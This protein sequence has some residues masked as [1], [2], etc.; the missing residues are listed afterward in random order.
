MTDHRTEESY[1]GDGLYASHDGCEITLRAPHEFGDHY[2]CMDRTVLRAFI[3]WG[4]CNGLFEPPPQ[5]TIQPR[6]RP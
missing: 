1:L 2:V 6:V 4:V 3:A 5:V